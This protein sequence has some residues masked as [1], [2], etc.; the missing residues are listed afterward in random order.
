MFWV[1]SYVGDLTGRGK[2]GRR[3][4]KW[5]RGFGNLGSCSL[6]Y[7]QVP[8]CNYGGIGSGEMN[9]TIFH[10]SRSWRK[11]ESG[12]SEAEVND[13]KMWIS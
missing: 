9:L 11:W 4:F 13:L 6:K 12:G 2:T 3:R 8:T 5:V 1:V 10:W 7:L